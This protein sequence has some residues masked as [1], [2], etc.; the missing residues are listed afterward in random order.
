MSWIKN[1]LIDVAITAVIA[2]FAWTGATWA[3]WIVAI[4]T[5]LMLLLKVFALSGAANAV[6]R[7]ADDVPVW[8]YHVLYAAN[9]I[10]LLVSSFLWAGGAWIAIWVLSAVAESRRPRTPKSAK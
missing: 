5:P 7:K 4:Y 8:F 1:A 6:Q 2:W 3:W 10:L 9:V